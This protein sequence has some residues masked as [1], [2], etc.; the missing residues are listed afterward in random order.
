[1]SENGEEEAAQDGGDLGTLTV[2]YDEARRSLDQQM[3][4]V[5]SLNNRAQQ[6]LGF[7]IVIA[8]VIASVDLREGESY[9]V[10]GI[11]LAS[12]VLFAIAAVLGFRA[13]RFRKYRD[14]PDP[15]SLY[16]GYRHSPEAVMREQVIGNR[17][18]SIE[19]NAETI[20]GKQKLIK[21]AL[22]TLIVGFG[23]LVVLVVARAFSADPTRHPAGVPWQHGKGEA[24]RERHQSP[25]HS[26]RASGARP[27]AD[28]G[29]RC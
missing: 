26:C 25:G 23:V 6:I 2:L 27:P 17:L 3:Q 10:R 9:W 4:L 29:S 5:E 22:W 28:Q 8:S 21:G 20:L 13:W 7:S 15:D 14:D 12:L 18:K 24:Q 1:M 11:G 19:A 16:R